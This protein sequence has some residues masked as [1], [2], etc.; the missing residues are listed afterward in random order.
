MEFSTTSIDKINYLKH[1]LNAIQDVSNVLALPVLKLK[2]DWKKADILLENY[3]GADQQ[4][5][6]DQSSGFWKVLDKINDKTLDLR[7]GYG[8]TY[9]VAREKINA[10]Y[11]E[12]GS[13]AVSKFT[14]NEVVQLQVDL[15]KFLTELGQKKSNMGIEQSFAHMSMGQ[16]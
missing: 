10:A 15:D 12:L 2:C 11:K 7:K 9:P 6:R 3:Y 8:A 14:Q 13:K 16:K 1:E 4:T 5:K